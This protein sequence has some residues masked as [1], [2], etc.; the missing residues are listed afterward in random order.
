MIT[1]RHF[2]AKD[3][4]FYLYAD[5]HAG[6]APQN[7]IVCAAVSA[8]VLGFADYAASVGQGEVLVQSP[9]HF[10]FVCRQIAMPVCDALL[11]TL[12]L[13]SRAY[14]NHVRVRKMR[15]GRE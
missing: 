9:G 11:H 8:S 7:D 3:G 15:P 2:M 12:H 14:P 13:I 6:F 10:R 4:S 1:V 5:G